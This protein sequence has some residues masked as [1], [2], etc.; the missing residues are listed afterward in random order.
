MSF[1]SIFASLGRALCYCMC[2]SLPLTAYATS[3]EAYLGYPLGEWHVRHDQVN[4]F[5]EKLAADNPR[6]SLEDTGYSHERR[7]QLTAVIT[8]PANQDRLN[9]IV[10]DRA[11]VKQG[12]ADRKSV[13]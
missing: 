2:L 12:K 3:L 1:L 8:S 13:V 9:G 6:V 11:L 4:G 10:A 5:L 7:R